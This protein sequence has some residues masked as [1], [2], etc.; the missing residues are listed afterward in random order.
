VFEQVERGRRAD[1]HVV[2]V[3][4]GYAAVV[5]AVVGYAVVVAVVGYAVVPKLE[6]GRSE[7]DVGLE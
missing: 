4:V 6:I 7:E 3:M 5:V 1:G 2:E